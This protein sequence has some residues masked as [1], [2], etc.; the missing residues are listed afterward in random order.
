MSLQRTFAI[1]KPD[2]VAKGN[3]GNILALIEKNGF[4]VVGLR[5]TRLTQAQAEAF[6][7]VHKERPFY[8][9]LV[10]FMTEGPVVVMALEKENAIGVARTDGR[11]ESGEG[12]RRHDPEVVRHRYR[13]QRRARFGRARDGGPGDSFLFRWFGIVVTDCN[14]K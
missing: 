4:Q 8:A 9:G 7:A 1:I 12:C 13:A 11:H 6:Y 2:A 10:K 5:K 14:S 3:A